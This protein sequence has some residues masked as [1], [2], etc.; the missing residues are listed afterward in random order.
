MVIPLEGGL[1]VDAAGGPGHGLEALE[2]DGLAAVDT[3]AIRAGVHAAERR[4]DL[5]GAARLVFGQAHA[6]I[7]Q[8]H[9]QGLVAII[10]RLILI[11]HV[12]HQRLTN[13]VV[14]VMEQTR[15]LLGELPAKIL[16]LSGRHPRRRCKP[17]ARRRI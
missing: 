16:Q 8:L 17:R 7:A 15:Q 5:L 4:L 13:L 3:H 9:A 12:P 11:E 6:R 14:H 1:V 2:L 10:T